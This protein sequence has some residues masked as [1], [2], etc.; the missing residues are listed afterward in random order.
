MKSFSPLILSIVLFFASCMDTTT[1]RPVAEKFLEAMQE[2][3]YEEAARYGTKETGKLLKQLERI[4]A[5]QAGDQRPEM[6][7]I[8]IVS[9]EIRGK[10]ATVYFREEGVPEEQKITLQRIVIQGDNG[11]EQK[12]WR[13]ALR[14]EEVPMPVVPAVE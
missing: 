3:N 10:T 5:L 1:P 13:V 11:K 8:T 6:G 9:E 4:E 2:R 14:K 12:E 7:K